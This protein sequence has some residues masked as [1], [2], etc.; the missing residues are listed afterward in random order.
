MAR[1][2]TYTIEL[3]RQLVEEHPGGVS[4]IELARRHD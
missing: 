2:R 3:E 1:Y 4:L